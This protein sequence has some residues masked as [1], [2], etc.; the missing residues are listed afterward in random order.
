MHKAVT[1]ALFAGLLAV[2]SV[3]CSA[4][5]DA[6]VGDPGEQVDVGFELT[7]PAFERENSIPSRYIRSG[8]TGAENIS[9]P[10]EWTRAPE[11]TKSFALVLIDVHPAARQWTHWMVVDIPAD[12]SSLVEGASKTAMPQGSRELS[13]SF[14]EVG[15]GG[16]EPP[17]GSGPHA[18]LAIIYALDIER[19]DVADDA[20]L[21]DVRR[22]MGGHV[23]AQAS[24][25]GVFER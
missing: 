4:E 12:I 3:G 22:A 1:V 18:Y 10:Y 24:F 6:R 19:L 7:S 23:L 11:G 25:R 5:P 2:I 17:V 20:G 8:V 13:N 16:P 15:Y 14:D 21:N 9:I